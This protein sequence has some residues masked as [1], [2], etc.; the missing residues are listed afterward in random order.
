[1]FKPY[2]KGKQN[3]LNIEFPFICLSLFGW[4]LLCEDHCANSEASQE[5]MGIRTLACSHCVSLE[6]GKPVR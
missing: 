2:K 4:E 1:M 3:I 5:Y 6:R